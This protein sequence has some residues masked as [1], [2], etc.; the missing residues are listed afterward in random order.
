MK[1]ILLAISFCFLITA[2]P[3]NANDNS[4]YTLLTTRYPRVVNLYW[5]TPITQA[6]AKKLA[7]WDM[8]ALSMDAQIDSSDSIKYIRQLNPKIVILA[9]TSATEIPLET[10]LNI[11]EPHGLGLWHDLISDISPEWYLKTTDGQNI[12]WWPG[13]VSMN[14]YATDKNGRTYGDYLSDFFAKKVLTTGLWDGLLFDNTWQNISYINKKIDI[15]ANG[16]IDAPEKIDGLWHESYENLFSQIRNQI[17]AKYLII[18]NG[19]GYYQTN[20]NGRMFEGFPEIGEG[21]W[22][23][24]MPKYQDNIIDGYVPRVNIINS[25]A[26]NTDNQNDFKDMRYGLSNTLMG[27]GFYSFDYGPDLREQ[28][29]WYD[30]YDANLGQPISTPFNFFDKNNASLTPSVW[31]RNF[32]QGIVLVNSTEQPQTINLDQPYE[33]INGTQ[34]LKVNNGETIESATI[35]AHDGLIL[36]KPITSLDDIIFINNYNIKIFSGDG[37][38]VRKIFSIDDQNFASNLKIINTD[39]NNDGQD[40]IITADKNKISIYNAD[41]K[42]INYFYP[43][44]TKYTGGISLAIGDLSGDKKTE[45]VVG[46]ETGNANLIKIFNTSGKLLRSFNAY[47]KNYKSIGAVSYTHLTLPTNREV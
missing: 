18:G 32:S 2:I 26:N 9:Y 25:D 42:L 31:Q 34:D 13:N 3:A 23:G 27:D 12:S 7:K 11:M 46:G 16:E 20:T 35:P 36:F 28:F 30:E 22:T 1:K 19:D 44:G 21:G 6:E 38:S 39:I 29:W 41:H 24:Q 40:E 37:R 14:L 45:I 15:D 17:G 43:L 5:K 33:K 10:R 4:N 8:L 47:N